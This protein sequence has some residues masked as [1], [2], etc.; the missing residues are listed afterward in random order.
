MILWSCGICFTAPDKIIIIILPVFH[1]RLLERILIHVPAQRPTIDDILNSQFVTC[2][3][4]SAELMQLELNL[5]S[6]PAKRSIFWVRKSHRLRKSASLRERY[7]EVVK[8]PAISM[9]TRQQDELFV[10]SFL[11]PIELSHE[12]PAVGVNTKELEANGEPAKRNGPGRRYLF[13]GTLKKKITPIETEPEK[14]LSNGGPTAK[15]SQW[16]IEVADDCPLFKNYDAETGSCVMLP[17]NTDDLSQLCA[18][19]FEARQ[20]LAE[21]GVSSQMLIAATPSGPRSDIIGAYR[22][23]VNRLQKQSWLARKHVEMALQMEPKPE[24]RIERQCCI[25]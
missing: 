21:L 4:L 15:L 9:N 19:E 12:Q 24:K 6:K 22:I 2:P 23:I 16:S 18:L 3:K 25:L 10:H 17:T 20:L 5:H 1:S 13:C 8:K 14:Q 7:A 11:H